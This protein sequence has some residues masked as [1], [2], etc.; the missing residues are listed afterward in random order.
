MQPM[1]FP[2]RLRDSFEYRR[3]FCTGSFVPNLPQTT[4]GSIPLLRGVMAQTIL[5][6]SRRLLPGTSRNLFRLPASVNP[7]KY[8]DT[9]AVAAI[10]RIPASNQGMLPQFKECRRDFRVVAAIQRMSAQL[11]VVAAIQRLLPF[12]KQ[13]ASEDSD[14]SCCTSVFSGSSSGVRTAGCKTEAPAASAI[15]GSSEAGSSARE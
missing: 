14:Q 9:R 8:R 6:V 13:P 10:Q 3:H 7:L 11:W 2:R 12:T 5:Q 1:A 15:P 4:A